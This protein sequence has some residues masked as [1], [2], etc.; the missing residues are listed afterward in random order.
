MKLNSL[1]FFLPL[2]LSSIRQRDLINNKILALVFDN[3]ISNKQSSILHQ[4]C[5][6]VK[7]EDRIA[8]CKAPFDSAVQDILRDLSPE[9]IN[10]VNE[11]LDSQ[12]LSR[13]EKYEHLVH[14]LGEPGLCFPE[15]LEALPLFLFCD[16]SCEDGF[17]E[18]NLEV[19]QNLLTQLAGD[20][21]CELNTTNICNRFIEITYQNSSAST[22]LSGVGFGSLVTLIGNLGNI[23][24]Q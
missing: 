17:C 21:G 23:S 22:L 13:Q 18:E 10:E 16:Q 7:D 11:I 4:G 24:F 15:L 6:L 19:I 9:E 8:E 3:P 1:V 14:I 20:L 2:A 5:I 12:Q